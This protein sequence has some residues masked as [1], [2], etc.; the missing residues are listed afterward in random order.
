MKTKQFGVD[1]FRW[2]CDRCLDQI[3]EW[4]SDLLLRDRQWIEGNQGVPFIH[5]TRK[6]GTHI[7]GLD[8]L[9]SYPPRGELAPYMFIRAYRDT[10]LDGKIEWL[11][12]VEQQHDVLQWLYFDGVKFQPTTFERALDIVRSYVSLIGRVWRRP[13]LEC[14][15]EDTSLPVCIYTQNMR[16]A[17]VVAERNPVAMDG[18]ADKAALLKLI[19]EADGH[20]V[21]LNPEARHEQRCAS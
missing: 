17:V 8:R 2:L 5:A 9:S 4:Q 10:F 15:C 6:W 3:E 21:W 1:T 20:L 11:K 18:G 14:L 12:A 13:A 7:I 16:I 19:L